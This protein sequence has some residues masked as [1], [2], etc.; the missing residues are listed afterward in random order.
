MF[1]PARLLTVLFLV[2]WMLGLGGCAT[3][4]QQVV[5]PGTQWQHASAE[6]MGLNAGKVQQAM[7]ALKDICSDLGNSRAILI[8]KGRIVWQGSDVQTQTAIWSSTKSYMSTCLGLLWDDGLCTPQTK[9]ADVCPEYASQYPDVTLEHLATFTSGYDH[10]KGDAFTP[11]APM[12]APGTAM[13]YSSQSDVLAYALTR[14]A[15]RPLNDLF[16]ERIGRPIGMDPAQMQWKDFGTKHD[17][18]INGGSGYPDSGLHMNALQMAR[19]GWLYACNGKWGG[20]Q[21]ISQRYID[22]ATHPRVPS[23]MP[24]YQANGWYTVLPGCYGLNWWV[25]GIEHNGNRKWPSAPARTFAAQGNRN[26]ICIIL[27]DWQMVLVRLGGDKVISINEYDKVL[28][29]LGESLQ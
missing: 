17:L 1:M 9:L 25:N 19:F 3:S 13:H 14:I 22:Y 28:K 12:Y 20:K 8:Y 4:T 6:A 15:G 21:L 11:A 7:A 26:N 5:F 10:L 16:M 23:D 29:L 18:L 27:P 2:S 24:P